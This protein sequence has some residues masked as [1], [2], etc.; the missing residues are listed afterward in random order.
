MPINIYNN[1]KD[2]KVAWLCE[3]DWGIA[4]QIF[5]LEKWLIFNL[6]KLQ[7]ANYTADIGYVGNKDAGGSSIMTLKLMEMLTSIG[8][9][10]WLSEYPSE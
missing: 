2:R 5:E 10:V 3:D 7:K 1:D 6:A 4:S 9:E 8:R